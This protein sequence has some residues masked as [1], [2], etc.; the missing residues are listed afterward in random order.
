VRVSLCLYSDFSRRPSRRRDAVT[1]SATDLLLDLVDVHERD[2]VLDLR[3]GVG[4]AQGAQGTGHRAS[5]EGEAGQNSKNLR[6]QI[7]S[8]PCPIISWPFFFSTPPSPSPPSV[9]GT[10]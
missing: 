7:D 1:D 4:Q 10:R 2:W 6:K 9:P 3:L 5:T 8:L